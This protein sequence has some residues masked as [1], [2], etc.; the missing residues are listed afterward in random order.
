MNCLYGTRTIEGIKNLYI[1]GGK[2][3]NVEFE[4]L[5][6]TKNEMEKGLKRYTG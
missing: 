2:N 5:V 3:W 4:L 6:M 1:E